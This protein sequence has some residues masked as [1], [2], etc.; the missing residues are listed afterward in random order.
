V[1]RRDFI[2]V[3]LGSSALAMRPLKLDAQS[4]PRRI[5]FVAPV[6]AATAADFIDELRGGLREHGF[7]D[8][9]AI[10]IESALGATP[11][12]LDQ[13]VAHLVRSHVD[14]IVAWSTPAV[15][16]AKRATTT[17]PIVMVG[18][19]DPVGSKF[20][21]SLARP[22]GNITGST[23]LS[24]DLSGKVLDILRQI[25]PGQQRLGILLNA[26]NAAA[27]L[28]LRDTEVAAHTLG[29]QLHLADAVSA[30][31]L[32]SAL[33]KLVAFGVT[34]VVVMP[35]PLFTSERTRIAELMLANGLPSAFARRENAVAGGL[36]SY[37]P[38]LKGQFRGAAGQTAKLLRGAAPAD[39]PVEQPTSLELAINLKTARA[40]GLTV[41]HSLLIT[42]DEVIE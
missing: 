11:E 41:P 21:D 42:A 7:V 16:A 2:V 10:K 37:G 28:Q 31:T 20:V 39:L 8:G 40:L 3:V 23:N 24:R 19:A 15:T 18:I 17:I 14:V 29:L 13:A 4:A 30:D 38:N 32:A 26:T 25:V 36:F 5:G 6:S 34:A 33:N 35:D 9:V 27:A 12:A 22:G 1:R